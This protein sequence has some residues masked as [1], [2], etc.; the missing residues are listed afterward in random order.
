M[1]SK[2][3]LVIQQKMIGDVLASTVICERLKSEYKDCIV[4]F[5]ANRNTLAVLEHNPHIDEIIVFEPQYRSSK[6]EFYRFLK[7]MQTVSYFALIDAYGKLESNLISLFSR[8]TYKISHPKWYTRWI[9]SHTVPENLVPDGRIPSALQNRLRLL[10]PIM[11]G[12]EVAM[13]PK[14]HL[15]E[16]EISAA[17]KSLAGLKDHPEQ[18]LIMIGILGSSP[19]KTYPAD[20]MARLLDTI[21]ERTEA[22]LLFNYIPHQKEA[23]RAIYEKCHPKTQAR[24]AIDFYADSL[25][26]FLGILSQCHALIGNEGGA[27]NMAKALQIPTFCLF[28]PFIVKGAWHAANTPARVGIHLRDYRPEAL[29]NMGKKEIKKNIP[30][31]YTAFEPQLFEEELFGFLH[32]NVNTKNPSTPTHA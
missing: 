24:I 23:V 17:Q 7:S 21:S 5:V 11:K 19:I 10:N 15:T 8:A 13:Y 27:V 9:Y 12:D 6:K 14:I 16:A 1:V 3:F 25:R 22:R 18:P 32:T 26:D 20:Y 2:K 29:N 4:H 30:T 31:L 28:S